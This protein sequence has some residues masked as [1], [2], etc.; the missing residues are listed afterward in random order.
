MLAL[1]ILL[2]GGGKCKRP[3]NN[4]DNHLEPPA[5][6]PLRIGKMA[7]RAI[8]NTKALYEGPAKGGTI[9]DEGI[10]RDRIIKLLPGV[11]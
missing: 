4:N 2:P 8:R 11:C 10:E 1:A 6:L 9:V 5:P 3:K 7:T